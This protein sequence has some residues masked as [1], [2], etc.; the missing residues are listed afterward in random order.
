[1]VHEPMIPQ[2]VKGGFW[3]QMVD[4]DDRDYCRNNEINW[5]FKFKNISQ[6]WEYSRCISTNGRGSIL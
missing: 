6:F 1:L 2:G 4:S 3:Y 5:N